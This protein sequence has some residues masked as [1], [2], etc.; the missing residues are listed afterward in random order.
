MKKKITLFLSLLIAATA[1]SLAATYDITFKGGGATLEKVKVENLTKGTS[2]EMDAAN[3]LRLTVLTDVEEVEKPQ[4]CTLYPNP[5]NQTST[6]AFENPSAGN[7]SIF[8]VDLQGRI[9]FTYNRFLDAGN[10][11]FSLGGLAGGIYTLVVKTPSVNYQTKFVSVNN[12]KSAFSFEQ[13]GSNFSSQSFYAP[14]LR[15]SSVP[16]AETAIVNMDYTEG[17]ELKFVGYA[18]GFAN[19]TIYAVPTANFQFTFNFVPRFY[20]VTGHHITSSFPNFVDVMF[21]VTD[22][23]RKGVDNL[24]NADFILKEDNVSVSPTESFRYVRSMKTVPYKIKTVVLIDN[25]SSVEN[26]LEQIKQAA[27]TLVDNRIPDQEMAI[28]VFS[29]KAYL[30]QDFTNDNNLLKQAINGI[31]LGFPSTNLYGAFITG[32][33]RWNDVFSTSGIQKGFLVLFTDGDD[34]QGSNTLQQAISARGNKS[35]YIV[36]LGSDLTPSVLNELANPSPY[37]KADK[38]SDLKPVFENIQKDIQKYA[39]S[40]Y[41]LNYMTPKRTG[42]HSLTI[43]VKENTNTG[44]DASHV[45]S[46]YA[47]NFISVMRGAFV[48]IAPGSAYGWTNLK[49]DKQT[50]TATITDDA[51]KVTVVQSPQTYRDTIPLTAVTYWAKEPPAYKWTTTDD[52]VAKVIDIQGNTARLIFLK[53]G[54][55]D[56]VLTDTANNSPTTNY[57]TSTVKVQTSNLLPEVSTISAEPYGSISAKVSG[58]VIS[59]KYRQLTRAGVCWSA[60]N[61]PVMGSDNFE[62]ATVDADGNFATE[63]MNKF[64]PSQNIY[65][66]TFAFNIHGTTY[67]TTKMLTM[68]PAAAPMIRTDSVSLI[69]HKSARVTLN[70]LSNNGD[71]L[72]EYGICYSKNPNPTVND[73]RFYGQ[74]YYFNLN[75]N[76]VSFTDLVGFTQLPAETKYYVRA[77]ARNQKGTTYGN[78]LSFTTHVITPTVM[79]GQAGEITTS[80]AE[81]YANVTSDEGL[82]VLRYGLCWSKEKNPTIA[83]DT[84]VAGTGTGYK[85]STMKNLQYNTKYYVRA[86]AT[87]EKITAYS[88]ESSFTTLDIPI[89][90]TY[91]ASQVFT[92]NQSIAPLSPSHTGGTIKPKVSAFAGGNSTYAEGVGS[93]AGFNNPS[94]IAIDNNG[95]LFVADKNN[96]LIRKILPDGTVTTFAGIRTQGF[97]DGK[98]GRFNNPSSITIDASG[99]LYVTD[100]G[101]HSIRKITLDGTVSTI[102]GNGQVGYTD[103]DKFTARFYSPRGITA[104]A[105][106]NLFVVDG[107]SNRIR[108]I[109]PQGIVSTIAGGEFGVDD[110]GTP[111]YLSSPRGITIDAAGNLY[112]SEAGTNRI[113]KITPDGVVSTIAGNGN[114]GAVDG[115]ALESSFNAP[116]GLTLDEAGNMYV[117][118]FSNYS[119]R[120]LSVTGLV[121]T[122]AGSNT[123]GFKDDYGTK[124]IFNNV[125]D[126]KIDKNTGFIYVAESARIRKLEY[127]TITPALPAGLKFNALTGIIS[128]TPTAASPATVYTISGGNEVS[129]G[130]AQITVEVK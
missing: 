72:L 76:L 29:D 130:T 50:T 16:Q 74:N 102:A 35:T 71:K 51:N 53:P 10:Q 19:T 66:R 25:S 119:I 97:S 49:I 94:G 81:Y 106:G 2:L 47:N 113:R 22:V 6:L 108:K 93:A 58:K 41:W 89:S 110:I 8:I 44:A 63:I 85:M 104:D 3:T 107:G 83:N 46:F 39:N 126:V 43:E 116:S 27:Q 59:K 54:N 26:T 129:V 73:T 15:P 9:M 111:V 45:G 36:G 55:A 127:Y 79:L 11:Q 124:A 118:D 31:Q 101:N 4:S 122:I 80:T 5:V 21:S 105:S 87:N 82:P 75:N 42:S 32:L 18:N 65:I 68:P 123:Y 128:G 56:I 95:N 91:A 13:T 114:R 40:F 48:N 78:E 33:N 17:D 30:L 61:N 112:V 109:A 88:T 92:A 24:V 12:Q 86:Y 90:F 28:Y 37:H 120:K 69:T 77:Y 121:S 125:N 20:R 117:A 99:N 96:H 57:F 103:G 34:T 7:V 70:V 84:T 100:E 115:K 62:Y 14:M 64:T 52:S 98:P 38:V 67:G 1:G 60:Y 23:N